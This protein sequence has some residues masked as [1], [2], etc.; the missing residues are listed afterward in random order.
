MM[1]V[2]LFAL[3]VAGAALG[4]LVSAGVR[5]M[6]GLGVRSQLPLGPRARHTQRLEGKLLY[7]LI[8]VLLLFPSLILLIHILSA[9]VS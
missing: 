5:A 9:L 6:M 8:A 7:G 2:M 1:T 3:L 4:A